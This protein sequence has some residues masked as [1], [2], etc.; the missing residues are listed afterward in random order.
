MDLFWFVCLKR[1]EMITVLVKSLNTPQNSY[2]TFLKV[3]VY[4]LH[5]NSMHPLRFLKQLQE[6][7]VVKLPGC[8]DLLFAN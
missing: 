7:S 1:T 8:E 3:A 4:C 2:S 6:K 5:A